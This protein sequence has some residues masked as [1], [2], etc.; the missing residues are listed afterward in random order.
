MGRNKK[1]QRRSGANLLSFK[2]HNPRHSW[3]NDKRSL[4]RFLGSGSDRGQ[5]SVEKG[6]FLLFVRSYVSP[7]GWPKVQPASPQPTRP[8][9]PPTGCKVNFDFHD[10]FQNSFPTK[11]L[12]PKTFYRPRTHLNFSTA[13]QAKKK[14]SQSLKRFF[15][16]K[17]F[18]YVL[19]VTMPSLTKYSH[20]AEI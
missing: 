6:D 4:I 7:L 2:L 14:F 11:P 9:A 10:L 8:R 5:C 1:P 18:S 3:I 19:P 13:P 20:A 15:F 16:H 17:I 12:A